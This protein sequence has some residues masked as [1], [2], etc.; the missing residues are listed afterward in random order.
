[1]RQ[2]SREAGCRRHSSAPASRALTVILPAEPCHRVPE[3]SSACTAAGSKCVT[4]EAGSALTATASAASTK[5][6]RT[7]GQ[8]ERAGRAGG[9]GSAPR[10]GEGDVGIDHSRSGGTID[11]DRIDRKTVA[12]VE[13]G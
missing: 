5:M 1:M 2:C 9:R 6:S 10:R 11:G 13:G 12:L 4:M 7:K 8:M 3:K